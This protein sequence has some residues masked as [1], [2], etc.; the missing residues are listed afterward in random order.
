MEFVSIVIVV[1]KSSKNV[2]SHGTSFSGLCG[3]LVVI[4]VVEAKN[5][6]TGRLEA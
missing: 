3:C 4:S 1:V 5:D 2:H 6:S